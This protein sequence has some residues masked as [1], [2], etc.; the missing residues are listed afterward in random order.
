MNFDAAVTNQYLDS[1]WGNLTQKCANGCLD[2]NV[3]DFQKAFRVILEGPVVLVK[4]NPLPLGPPIPEVFQIRLK[5][6]FDAL[7]V[8]DCPEDKINAA[9]RLYRARRAKADWNRT[10]AFLANAKSEL[11]QSSGFHKTACV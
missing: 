11:K 2:W 1:C 7:T 10:N 3:I 6:S 4:P 8:A 5:N 9:R